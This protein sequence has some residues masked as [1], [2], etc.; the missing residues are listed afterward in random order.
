VSSS[1]FSS[2]DSIE[3]HERSSHK[4]ASVCFVLDYSFGGE[5]LGQ[6]SVLDSLTKEMSFGLEST[7]SSKMSCL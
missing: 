4:I 3:G 1:R 5:R 7:E 6:D 2:S